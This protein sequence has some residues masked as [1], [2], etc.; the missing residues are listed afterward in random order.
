ME[1][2]YVYL[3]SNVRNDNRVNTMAH[4]V[5]QLPKTMELDDSFE[6]GLAELSYTQS[7]YTLTKREE[8]LLKMEYKTQPLEYRALVQFEPGV[9]ANALACVEGINR[10]LGK[11]KGDF[12]TM[13]MK[14][15]VLVYD[16]GSNRVMEQLGGNDQCTVSLNMSHSMR[17][18]LGVSHPADPESIKVN[19]IHP[20][21]TFG[22]KAIFIYSDIVDFSVVGDSF[23]QLLRIAKT[24]GEYKFGQ[25]VVE[26]Y[27]RPQYSPLRKTRFNT[28]EIE[29]RDDA[30][31]NMDDYY[32]QQAGSGLA[33]Y[34]GDRFQKGHGFMT[35]LIATALPLLKKALPYISEQAMKFG[36][37]FISDIGFGGSSTVK[38]AAK[39]AV[40]RRAAAITEDA[41][42]KVK[43]LQ[44]GSGIRR[45][46][47][48]VAKP[49]KGRRK[50]ATKRKR[51]MTSIHQLSSIA[52]LPELDLF[53]VPPTQ[54][55]VLATTEKEFRPV[56]QLR[57]PGPIEFEIR[58]GVNEYIL[59][60]ET[61]L[62]LGF[63]LKLVDP[64]TKTCCG[65]GD[66]EK[67]VQPVQYLMHSMFK[68]VELSV[69]NKPLSRAPQNYAYKAYF[70]A[71]LGYGTN[72]KK[73]FL[74]PAGW[75]TDETQ[76]KSFFTPSTADENSGKLIELTGTLHLDLAHQDRAILGGTPLTL[77][78]IP[79]SANFFLK[80]S[81]ADIDVYQPVIEFE[82][83]NLM[84]TIQETSG[85]LTD[86]HNKALQM[87]PANLLLMDTSEILSALKGVPGFCG[88][89]PAD[90]LRVPKSFP[91][92]VVV[93]TDDSGKPGE[94][95]VAIHWPNRSSIEYFDSFGFPPLVP[96]I[97]KVVANGSFTYNSA[98]LQHPATS[99]C[100]VYCIA[101]VLSRAKGAVNPLDVES[102]FD[103]RPCREPKT[104]VNRRFNSSVVKLA[105]GGTAL[106]YP[107]GQVVLV[108]AKSEAQCREMAQVVSSTLAQ[109]IA[110]N[111]T[112]SNYVASMDCGQRFTLTDFKDLI[113]VIY[114]FSSI[115]FEPELFNGLIWDPKYNNNRI[116]VFVSGKVNITGCKSLNEI[117]VC[118][119]A[120][121]TINGVYF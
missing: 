39:K 15:P 70:E 34:R 30:D 90:H 56:N 14:V 40:K 41:L 119:N 20:D 80:V 92:S 2:F 31:V 120:V 94:H 65:R 26:Q 107:S 16:Q 67:M 38:E 48:T 64:L 71:L 49:I 102:K 84:T 19:N 111:V 86:A 108:G 60:N 82:Y 12:T 121:Q 110:V 100:G 87:A 37:D 109:E 7:W 58:T 97:A 18:M 79:N 96:R 35:G 74:R 88:V 10:K 24:P 59:L 93:N 57:F 117:E 36:K 22:R 8:I 13:G 44:S 1:S 75:L 68:S 77:K 98:T 17:E 118:Y 101:F 46:R 73:T 91:A 66:Y 47:R 32:V 25:Q 112:V 33:F 42:V 54:V 50:T 69:M 23:S 43:K 72:A 21:N 114:P 106:I 62:R 3:P 104:K 45:K 81:E 28:I 113:E 51:H 5:T 95:W 99:T 27:D 63:R 89:F 55:S 9:Y 29:L 116:I 11:I 115:S 6:V 83:C 103:T 105:G 4:Y 76:A 52:T 53:A 78:L 61:Y 85:F